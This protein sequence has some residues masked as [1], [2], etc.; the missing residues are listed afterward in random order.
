MLFLIALF[1]SVQQGR[2]Q[3]L[4]EKPAFAEPMADRSLQ[5]S[6]LEI[7]TG[8]R[9]VAPATSGT[10]PVKLP[11]AVSLASARSQTSVKKNWLP[12][13]SVHASQQT[14][15]I[16]TAAFQA[17]AN[18]AKVAA[19]RERSL[20]NESDSRIVHTS[21]FEPQQPALPTMPFN[22]P[23][24]ST[25]PPGYNPAASPPSSTGSLGSGNS[26]LGAPPPPVNVLPTMPQ[27]L[28]SGSSSLGSTLPPGSTNATGGVNPSLPSYGVRPATPPAAAYPM[29]GINS[30]NPAPVAQPFGTTPAAGG[31][32]T[33]I[34]PTTNLANPLSGGTIT[35][36]P[37][38]RY[39][40]GEPFVTLP[41]RQVQMPYTYVASSNNPCLPS[42]W[43]NTSTAGSTLPP[44]T[45]PTNTLA[46]NGTSNSSSGVLPSNNALGTPQYPGVPGYIVPPTVTPNMAPQLFTPNNS[47]YTSLA[48]WGTQSANVTVGRGLFGTPTVYVTNEPIGNF[49][50]YMFH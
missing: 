29:P 12:P 44:G 1:Q 40:T 10:R 22:Q 33:G 35:P 18:T 24:G 34:T 39:V 47:G 32:T 49:F 9:P 30:I 38:T 5:N 4:P 3:S 20:L 48:N 31:T 43:S 15:A 26:T 19:P 21:Y 50:R 41:P 28:N 6:D 45:V 27:P 7:P 11:Q 14:N 36:T 37:Q 16:T 13:L 42:P 8:R 23:G 17:A 2:A 46:N 25:L